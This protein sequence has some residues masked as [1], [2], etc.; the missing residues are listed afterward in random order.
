[1]KTLRHFT[2]LLALSTAAFAGTRVTEKAQPEEDKTSLWLFS[3]ETTYTGLSR[4]HGAP[5]K[6]D[7]F[8]GDYSIDRRFPISGHWY[9]RVGA[10]YERFDFGGT[11]RGLPNHLQAFYAHLATEYIVHDHAGAGLSIE[12]GFYFQNRIGRDS[13]DIP[14]KI[15]VTFPLK[16]D[17]V[18][19]VI[20]A[21]GSLYQDPVVAPGGGIIWLINDKLRL[22][23]VVP[24]P[25]LVYSPNDNWEVRVLGEIVYQSF[26]TD[27]VTLYGRVRLRNAVVQYSEYRAGA[28]VSYSGFKPFNIFVG[29][30]YTFERS[31]DFYRADLTQHFSGAPYIKAGIE[32][33]F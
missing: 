20:G 24:K 3:A 12:P 2:C 29:G 19:G 31:F 22:E 17:K 4:Y 28:Q 27:D 14:W 21:G 8:Y 32:A 7:S 9:F 16:K 5:G 23:G 6:G 30:G 10:E 26:R 15:W 11:G 25:A 18:Y 1:M 33:K 13:F